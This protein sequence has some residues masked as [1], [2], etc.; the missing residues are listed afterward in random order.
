[1]GSRSGSRCAS[2]SSMW[3]GRRETPRHG[4][5]W[6]MIEM[7]RP[8][9]R[10]GGPVG[11]CRLGDWR[12]IA[13]PEAFASSPRK[14]GDPPNAKWPQG[15]GPRFDSARL[16]TFPITVSRCAQ[17]ARRWRPSIARRRQVEARETV[18]DGTAPARFAAVEVFLNVSRLGRRGG[19]SA[20]AELG[21]EGEFVITFGLNPE[22][23]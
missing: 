23:S 17:R 10:G 20:A 14:C 11:A 19:A 7:P 3:T 21:V 18:R 9:D 2:A 22:P 16:A 13:V 8:N 15:R 5:P 12:S 6:V 4:R 1:M